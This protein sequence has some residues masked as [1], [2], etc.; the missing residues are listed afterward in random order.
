MSAAACPRTDE[1][2]DALGRGFTGPELA[3][4]VAQCEACGEIRLVAGAVLDERTAALREAPVPTAGTMWWRMQ[5]RQRRE[6]QARARR[7][8]AVGQ[9]ATIAIAVALFVSLL[10]PEVAGGVRDLVAAVRFGTPVLL[11]AATWILVAP[12]AGYVALRRVR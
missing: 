9:A 10:G 2:L 4:H 7:S 5:M 6:A 11:V 12:I 8:L 1:L 3:G